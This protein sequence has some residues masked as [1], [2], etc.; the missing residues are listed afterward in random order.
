[1]RRKSAVIYLTNHYEK[2]CAP[3]PHHRNRFDPVVLQC[4]FVVSGAASHTNELSICNALPAPHHNS[5]SGGC[6]RNWFHR[7]NYRIRRHHR[8]D[9]D[10]TNFSLSKILDAYN[11]GVSALR[12]PSQLTRKLFSTSG[13]SRSVR[14]TGDE[15]RT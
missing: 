12:W 3:F 11:L 7:R 6:F 5:A 2:T 13:P 14:P 1:M 10:R 15:N 9:S 4:R 8:P